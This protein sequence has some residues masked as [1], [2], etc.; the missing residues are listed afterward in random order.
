MPVHLH[1][2]PQTTPVY[3]SFIHHYQP[4]HYY[5]PPSLFTHSCRGPFS[6]RAGQVSLENHWPVPSHTA[7]RSCC[8]QIG[9][10]TVWCAARV[11]G[12]TWASAAIDEPWWG[13]ISRPT[14]S[15]CGVWDTCDFIDGF[16]AAYWTTI[17]CG[18]EVCVCVS[19][20]L[21][22]GVWRMYSTPQ[23]TQPQHDLLG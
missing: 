4:H 3:I 9:I 15:A 10:S 11:C 20:G 18:V 8:K 16:G 5:H 22:C 14:S 21:R 17:L 12:I 1:A 19:V 13:C 23:H 2:P 6:H 7:T